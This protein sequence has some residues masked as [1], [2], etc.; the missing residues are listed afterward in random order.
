V[1]VSSKHT[2]GAFCMP[3]LSLPQERQKGGK[4]MILQKGRAGGRKIVFDAGKES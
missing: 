2:C 1:Y 3:P 4:F